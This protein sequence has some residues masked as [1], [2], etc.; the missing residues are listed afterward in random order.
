VDPNLWLAHPLGKARTEVFIE[1]A[2]GAERLIGLAEGWGA[3]AQCR[4]T[5]RVPFNI[6]VEIEGEVELAPLVA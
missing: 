5:R 3:C 4:R 1:Q 2:Y 6:P